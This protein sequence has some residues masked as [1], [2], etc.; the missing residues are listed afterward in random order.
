MIS[1][2]SEKKKRANC[3]CCAVVLVSKYGVDR[4]VSV[5]SAPE[6]ESEVSSTLE[7]S[8]RGREFQKVAAASSQHIEPSGSLQG[9]SSEKACGTA[10][11]LSS[12]PPLSVVS[13]PR[14]PRAREK[15]RGKP[16][17]LTREESGRSRES[18]GET[19]AKRIP[20]RGPK[21]YYIPRDFRSAL[22]RPLDDGRAAEIDLMYI[23]IV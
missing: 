15:A 3:C 18:E 17:S 19:R 8:G 12:A 1:R 13:E 7:E 11:S 5:K 22:R 9:I 23:C 6:R 16:R 10:Q 2:V 14:P 4:A 20:A 21:L